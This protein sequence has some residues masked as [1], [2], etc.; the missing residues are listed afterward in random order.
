MTSL[1]TDEDIDARIAAL[2]GPANEQRSYIKPLKDIG[3]SL[4]E[5]LQVEDGIGTGL[6]QIDVLT[7]GFRPSDLVVI[8][9]FASSGKTQLVNSMLVNSPE[10]KCV[11]FS[12]DD[13]AE[14]IL[15]KLVAMLS[16]MSSVRIEEK[17]KAGDEG[18]KRLVR[19]TAEVQ[20]PNLL[21][22]DEVLGIPE[23]QAAVAEATVLWGTHP[24]CVVIDYC[25]I[26]ASGDRPSDD[27][28]GDIKRKM[29]ALKTWAKGSP[30]PLVVIHQGSRSNAKLGE[31]ITLTS[32]YG[33]GEQQ[34][35]IVVGVRR[36]KDKA[37]LDTFARNQHEETVTIHVVKCKRPGGRCT[38]FEG[39]DFAMSSATGL[40]RP[41]AAADSAA[42]ALRLVENT[43]D[44]TQYDF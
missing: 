16:G 20:L 1:L 12:L 7:R 39:V 30:Y 9:G 41:L 8:T 14:M 44:A 3:E 6:A 33:S 4:I 13:P 23:M 43:L 22:V 2:S 11:F 19:E 42:T 38:H 29:N 32:M 28:S 37:D 34:A 25:E 5:A 18:V 31:P 36:K 10:K 24:D 21:I 15:A 27:Q 40:I 35:S 26:I 17:V